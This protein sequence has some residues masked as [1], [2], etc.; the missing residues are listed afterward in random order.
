MTLRAC[1]ECG[2]TVSS[3][4]AACPHCGAAGREPARNTVVSIIALLAMLAGGVW[5]FIGIGAFA[6]IAA[7]YDGTD[8]AAMALGISLLFNGFLF[9]LPGVVVFLLGLIGFKR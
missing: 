9:V 4:A 1:P 6:T 8:A 2:G 3:K 5:A 7:S